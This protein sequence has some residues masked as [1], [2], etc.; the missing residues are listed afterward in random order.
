MVSFQ[1]ELFL[2]WFSS[3]IRPFQFIT[4]LEWEIMHQSYQNLQQTPH[5][6]GF[7]TPV[8]P[9]GVNNPNHQ[10]FKCPRFARGG[11]GGGEMYVSCYGLLYLLI[12]TRAK[13][14]VRSQSSSYL[15]DLCSLPVSWARHVQNCQHGVLRIVLNVHQQ[16]WFSLNL[17]SLISPVCFLNDMLCP[18]DKHETSFAN[19]EAK[20]NFRAIK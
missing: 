9:E 8:W 20:E 18:R 7:W 3:N 4:S 6:Q 2:D 15:M 1:S 5:L 13:F 10:K 17:F 16:S 14:L 19:M 11:G 12:N